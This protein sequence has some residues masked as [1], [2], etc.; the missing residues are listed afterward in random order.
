MEDRRRRT[1]RTDAVLADPRL[2]EAADRLGPSRVKQAVAAAL[3][4]CRAGDLE[5]EAVPDAALAALP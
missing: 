3:D 4:R 1:P 2:R 5:P